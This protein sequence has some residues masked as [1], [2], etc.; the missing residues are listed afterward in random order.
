MAT[1]ATRG[2]WWSSYQQK[3]RALTQA[4]VVNLAQFAASNYTSE[5]PAKVALIV[6]AYARC[7]GSKA[8]RRLYS[9]VE[10]L[11][12]KEDA[13][14]ASVQGMECLV[15]LAKSYTDIGQPRRAWLT[16]RRGLCMAQFLSLSIDEEL[17]AISS[18]LPAEWWHV[19]TA[20]PDSESGIMELREKLLLQFYFHHVR[21]YLHLP[22]L[23][24]NEVPAGQSATSQ[25]IALNASRKM[26]ELLLLLRAEV[27]PGVPL[28]ECATSDFVGLTAAVILALCLYTVDSPGKAG[29]YEGDWQLISQARDMFRREARRNAQNAEWQH[30]DF[31]VVFEYA[32][33]SGM[34]SNFGGALNQWS[35]Y[36]VDLDQDWSLF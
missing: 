29:R 20:L 25:G 7:I 17:E 9:L 34:G 33:S 4:P 31:D 36:L 30:I 5:D 8:G 35:D 24:T 2:S 19:P 12:I 26:L 28:F 10:G 1:F 23:A 27:S 6:V 11:V 14:L 18:I 15:L 3:T 16:W 21:T 13:Y 22:F 32:G